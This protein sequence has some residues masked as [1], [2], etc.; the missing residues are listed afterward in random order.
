MRVTIHR[1]HIDPARDS[2]D[3]FPFGQ[4]TPAGT[5]DNDNFADLLN[6]N[7][8][9]QMHKGETIFNVNEDDLK[10]ECKIWFK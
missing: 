8:L 1:R 6:K 5:I 3:V 9:I 7:Q 10:A 2:L 4:S